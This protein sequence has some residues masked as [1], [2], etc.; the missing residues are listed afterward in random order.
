MLVNEINNLKNLDHPNILKIYEIFED[1]KRF[2]IVT[3]ICK[4]GELFDVI[5]SEKQFSEEE[6]SSLMK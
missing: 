4:G 1:A 3:D 6:A 5:V 2:Y